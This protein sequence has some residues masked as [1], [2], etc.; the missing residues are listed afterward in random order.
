MILYGCTSPPSAPVGT[1]YSCNYAPPECQQ[2]MLGGSMSGDKGSCGRGG[3]G[4]GQ[5]QGTREAR[6]RRGGIGQGETSVSVPLPYI[7]TLQLKNRLGPGPHAPEP[8]TGGGLPSRAERDRELRTADPLQQHK[9]GIR[10]RRQHRIPGHPDATPEA[11]G[12]T[13]GG[14][15]PEGAHSSPRAAQPLAPFPHPNLTLFTPLQNL[16]VLTLGQKVLDT[17]PGLPNHYVT[18]NVCGSGCTALSRPLRLVASALHM[19]Q[20]RGAEDRRQQCICSSTPSQSP[21]IRAPLFN[22]GLVL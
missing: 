12:S 2:F 21:L 4:G 14:T 10:H 3:E 20:V 19:H 16:W 1:T 17:P 22:T 5:C 18:P 11:Q 8:A 13:G 9:S 15:C 7:L 6:E